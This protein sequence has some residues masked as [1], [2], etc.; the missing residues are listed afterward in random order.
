MTFQLQ[1]QVQPSL[2][3]QPLEDSIQNA[4][5]PY[6]IVQKYFTALFPNMSQSFQMEQSLVSLLDATNTINRPL[7]INYQRK[8]LRKPNSRLTAFLAILWIDWLWSFGL[9]FISTSNQ[10]ALLTLGDFAYHLVDQNRYYMT[11]AIL[12]VRSS[13]L[14]MVTAFYFDSGDWLREADQLF[15][16]LKT[17]NLIRRLLK[18]RKTC[19]L[20]VLITGTLLAFSTL[21]S[22]VIA[23]SIYLDRNAQ[24]FMAP[25]YCYMTFYSILCSFVTCQSILQLYFIC[26]LS[27][28]VFQELNNDYI[29]GLAQ[30]KARNFTQYYKSFSQACLLTSHL[31]S[32]GRKIYLVYA[33]CNLT[34]ILF[35]L[36]ATIYASHGNAYQR[37]NFIV[38]LILNLGFLLFLSNA[39]G[40]IDS[41]A[42]EVEAIVYEEFV[43]HNSSRLKSRKAYWR[44]HRYFQTVWMTVISMTVLESPISSATF[45]IVSKGRACVQLSIRASHFIEVYSKCNLLIYFIL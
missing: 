36:Y 9:S 45:I 33:T 21:L 41:A 38:Y 43:I 8:A 23:R 18:T 10:Q 32:Y 26:R 15:D 6:L 7:G 14:I 17:A 28:S 27:S 25:A 1:S 4:I 13:S 16:N 2:S 39:I 12:A 31:L 40:S 42:K 34:N 44:I 3:S 30:D 35:S 22:H 29:S 11:G 20:A 19:Q 24:Y 37:L 5:F